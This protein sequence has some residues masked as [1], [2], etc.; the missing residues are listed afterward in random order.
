MSWIEKIAF[1]QGIRGEEPNK[2]LAHEIASSDNTEALKEI[3]E[4]LYDKNKSISSDVLATMYHVGYEKPELIAPYLETFSDLLSSKI[5]RMVWGS[6]IAL[7]TIANVEPDALF[8]KIDLLIDTIKSGSLITEVWGLATLVN[9]TKANEQYEQQTLPVLISY[10]ESCRPIDFAK[11]VE[12]YLPIIN[13]SN[14]RDTIQ[15]IIKEKRSELSEA[16]N[17]K[18]TTILKRYNKSCSAD[19]QLVV[20]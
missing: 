19:L 16:Q 11:R 17:K 12:T 4:Y 14:K 5:N 3:S 20:S 6:M 10:L 1:H 18:L 9:I 15:N 2:A 7:S 13:D 8:Q